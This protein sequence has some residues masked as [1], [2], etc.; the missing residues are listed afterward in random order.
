MRASQVQELG[1]LYNNHILDK[2]GVS[3]LCYHN[4]CRRSSPE[5]GFSY[6]LIFFFCFLL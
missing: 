3:L 2:R 1:C 4:Y 6:W 5:F